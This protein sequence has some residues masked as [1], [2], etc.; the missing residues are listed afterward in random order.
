MMKQELRVL[1]WLS[2]H[3]KQGITQ[4]EATS[5]LG[6]IRLAARIKDLVDA[7]YGIR[8]EYVSVRNRYGERCRVMRYWLA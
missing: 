5:E 6:I 3:R 8:R 7:G 4:L 2:H 1:L